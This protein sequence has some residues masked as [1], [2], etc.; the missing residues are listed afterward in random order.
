M[1]AQ[2]C[3]DLAQLNA[4]AA[5]LD[6]LVEAPEKLEGPIRPVAGEIPRSL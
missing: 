6:L 4:E 1:L 3:L 2:H 5:E